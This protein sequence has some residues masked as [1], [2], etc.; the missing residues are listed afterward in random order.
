MDYMFLL[1]KNPELS[2]AEIESFLSS[3]TAYNVLE[4]TDLFLLADIEHP[5]D[6]GML[7]GT[8]KVAQMVATSLEATDF[9]ALAAHAENKSL[10][11]LVVM[12]DTDRKEAAAFIKQQIKK[13]GPHLGYRKKELTHTELIKKGVLDTGFE[14]ILLP[15]RVCR[16]VFAHNPFEF[17]KR[18]LERPCQRPIFSIPPRLARIMLNLAQVHAGETACDPFCGTGTILQEAALMGVKPVGSDINPLCVQWARKNLIWIRAQ[19]KKPFSFDIIH[20]DARAIGKQFSNLDC[21]VTEPDLGP[22]LKRPPSPNEA[23]RIFSSLR[24]LYRDFFRAA[25]IALKPGG[26]LCVVVP[27]FRQ[28]EGLLEMGAGRLLQAAGFS[29]HPWVDSDPRDKTIRQI[30]VAIK[31]PFK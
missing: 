22:P 3:R 2:V 12:D 27:A 20:T 11:S 31:T 15:K 30:W 17:R 9:S 21:I 5:Q 4:K 10:F 6:W 26:R 19:Y 18:D 7:G 23:E 24:P 29:A 25:A 1:G 28:R 13:A 14:L 16:T 8:L